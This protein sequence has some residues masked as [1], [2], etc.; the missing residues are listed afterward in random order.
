MMRALAA[1]HEK[2]LAFQLVPV[3]VGAGEHKKERFL[4]LNPFGQVP[5]FE[6]GDL[7]LF[8]SRAITQYIA[9]KYPDMG[10]PLILE[11]KPTVKVSA[12]MEF[13]VN[14]ETMESNVQWE[15]LPDRAADAAVIENT[16]ATVNMWIEV[17]AHQFDP[18]ASRLQRE[19]VYRQMIGMAPD[20][21]VFGENWTRLTELLDIYEAQL[22]QSK[23]LGCDFFTLADLHHLP[24][25][26][27]LMGTPAKALF[28]ARP[29]VSAWVANIMA[30]PAWVKV[31]AL[32]N[33]Y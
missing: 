33:Q 9:R 30:R 18:V 11:S 22:S 21:A 23:Y 28:D 6:D 27:N 31:L 15:L 19:L 20:T 17:E 26:T 3:D 7:K 4:A 12:W 24:A 2:G 25:L 5:A 32:R 16:M 14:P 10:T 29:K 1:L 13:E 8:E